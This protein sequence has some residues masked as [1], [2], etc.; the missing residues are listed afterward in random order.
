ML[1]LT[2]LNTHEMI[3]EILHGRIDYIQKRIIELIG[4]N[5]EQF[6]QVV[7]LPQGKFERFLVANSEDKKW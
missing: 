2:F 5:K 4:L 1:Q 6:R 3:G 7:L